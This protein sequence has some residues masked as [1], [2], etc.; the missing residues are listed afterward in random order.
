MKKTLLFATALIFL[1]LDGCKV[2]PPPAPYIICRGCGQLGEPLWVA[3]VDE[4]GTYSNET[5]GTDKSDGRKN[6]GGDAND[7]C[8]IKGR[9]WYLPAIWELH[10]VYQVDALKKTFK[11]GNY[12]SSTQYDG[13]VYGKTTSDYGYLYIFNESFYTRFSISGQ[14]PGMA[15]RD[16]KFRNYSVRCFWKPDTASVIEK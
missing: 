7:R 10:I 2:A 4:P 16:K 1:V 9:G 8:S 5:T 6:T 12:W 13:K 11:Q 14:K 3:K 15:Y